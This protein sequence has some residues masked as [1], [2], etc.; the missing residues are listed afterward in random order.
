MAT[1]LLDESGRTP[2][3]TKRRALFQRAD[4]L[5]AKDLPTIPL[6][7]PPNPLIRK[8]SLAGTSN[9]PSPT[10]FAWNIQ[11]WHWR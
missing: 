11:Q 4:A 5:F 7:S 8:S 2:D 3:P 10:G 1:T 6:Y 9:N